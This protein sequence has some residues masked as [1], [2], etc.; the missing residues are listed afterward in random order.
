MRFLACKWRLILHFKVDG[1]I[2]QFFLIYSFHCRTSHSFSEQT[3]SL[4]HKTSGLNGC[5]LKLKITW[6]GIFCTRSSEAY[7]WLISVFIQYYLIRDELLHLLNRWQKRN[8]VSDMDDC[9]NIM[10][11]LYLWISLVNNPH[12]FSAEAHELY[13]EDLWLARKESKVFIKSHYRYF[14][15][16]N[17][18]WFDNRWLLS[19]VDLWCLL[20][21]SLDGLLFLVIILVGGELFLCFYAFHLFR[22]NSQYYNNI[23]IFIINQPSFI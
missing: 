13:I 7:S 16:I 23:Q 6:W 21:C 18:I 8:Y 17:K 12:L 9:Q 14:Q 22:L 15:I 3:L 2:V 5:T 19:I 10:Q 4:L 11:P 1:I 20:C